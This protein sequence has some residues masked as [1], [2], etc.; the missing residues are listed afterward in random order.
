[1]VSQFVAP[2]LIPFTGDGWL[3]GLGPGGVYAN[4]AEDVIVSPPLVNYGFQAP[5]NGVIPSPITIAAG[6]DGRNFHYYADPISGIGLNTDVTFQ[7]V[8]NHSDPPTT[9]S[10]LYLDVLTSFSGFFTGSPNPTVS[11]NASGGETMVM[12]PDPSVSGPALELTFNTQVNRVGIFFLVGDGGTSYY[13]LE[14]FDAGG[15]Q[16]ITP[17]VADTGN[18]ANFIGWETSNGQDLTRIVLRQ[19]DSLGVPVAGSS[20]SS[21]FDDARYEFDPLLANTEPPGP[22]E[23]PEPSTLALAALGLV[24]VVRH[25][26]RAV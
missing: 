7:D 26:R 4:P 21:V 16:G 20:A 24:Y 15:S 13:T 25:R 8:T 23:I 1:L 6:T 19:T 17:P 11:A 18:F 3:S 22:I 14:A 2:I 12:T 9:R 5:D 10:D